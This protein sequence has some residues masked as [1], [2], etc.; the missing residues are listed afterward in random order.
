[1]QISQVLS[2]NRV[3]LHKLH[4]P[5]CYLGDFADYGRQ[6]H[7]DD[8]DTW[9]QSQNEEGPLVY[10]FKVT[11]AGQVSRKFILPFKGFYNV[12]YKVLF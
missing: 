3:F 11:S 4:H 8:R 12:F 10:P 1:M 9:S 2:I 5:P 6:S 7:E